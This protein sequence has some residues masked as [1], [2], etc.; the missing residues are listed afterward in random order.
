MSNDNNDEYAGQ[1]GAFERDP[2]T[3]KRILIER[4]RRPDEAAPPESAA[5]T[6]D[7]QEPA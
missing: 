6:E 1:G 4:T 3:G 7:S 2:A 5:P